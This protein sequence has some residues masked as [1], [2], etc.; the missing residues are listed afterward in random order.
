MTTVI[1]GDT[2]VSQVQA[3]SINQDDLAT[4]VVGKGPAFYAYRN[5]AFSS[6]AGTPIYVV[7]DIEVFD[8]NNNFASGNFTP[9]VAGYYQVNGAVQ[10]VE[11]HNIRALLIKNGA[12]TIYGNIC[13]AASSVGGLVYMNGTTDTISL[14]VSDATG[15]FNVTTGQST[16]FF[17]GF[18][19][20]AA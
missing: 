20:R 3:G 18:L 9:T 2:G 11:S 7:C 4:N 5:A 8:T 13:L 15:S 17:S 14:G 10:V 12:T 6:G 16:T 1:S 19:A